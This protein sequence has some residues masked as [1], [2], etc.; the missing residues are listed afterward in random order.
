MLP[1]Y[2][3]AATHCAAGH[4]PIWHDEFHCPLCVEMEDRAADETN[5]TALEGQIYQLEALLE[6]T[7]AADVLH[8]MDEVEK[9]QT[10]AYNA[11]TRFNKVAY[12]IR[13]HYPKPL[14]KRLA[15]ITA[16]LQETK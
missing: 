5:R 14:G 8:L 12:A 1:D 6:E 10:A 3:P 13:S 2:A 11:E 7:G 4:V 9:C 16:A 15:S